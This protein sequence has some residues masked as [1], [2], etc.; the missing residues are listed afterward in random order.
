MNY[1]PFI[2]FQYYLSN[3]MINFVVGISSK[4]VTMSDRKLSQVLKDDKD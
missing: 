2:S 1:F 4:A 3:L